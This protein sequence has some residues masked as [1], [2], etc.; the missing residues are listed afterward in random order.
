MCHGLHL[1]SPCRVACTTFSIPVLTIRVA[2]S[3]TGLHLPSSSSMSSTCHSHVHTTKWRDK[4]IARH[5][6]RKTA[7]CLKARIKAPR[8][9]ILRGHNIKQPCPP[10][11]IVPRNPSHASVSVYKSTANDTRRPVLRHLYSKSLKILLIPACLVVWDKVSP[12]LVLGV[13][14]K[15]LS[16]TRPAN[17]GQNRSALA[18]VVYTIPVNAGEKRVLLD[19][20]NAT[21][22]IAETT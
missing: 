18:T 15:A 9:C 2:R 8:D 22:Q 10:S 4:L 6:L 20:G 19:T 14:I 1:L 17:R 3:A 21:R 5:S 12:A 11:S 16:I 13:V 7:A